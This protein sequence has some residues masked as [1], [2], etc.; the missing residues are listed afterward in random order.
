VRDEP[1]VALCGRVAFPSGAVTVAATHLSFV[2]GV[3][4]WQLRRLAAALRRLPGPYL[5]LGDLNLPAP[6]PARLTGLVPLASARTF[7]A[8]AP[9]AQLDHVLASR[10]VFSVVGAQA[11]EMA[12]SDHRALAVEVA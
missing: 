5:L 2:P 1:R 12:V 7:P 3:N 8:P 10:G 4:A 6:V 11:L 9:R